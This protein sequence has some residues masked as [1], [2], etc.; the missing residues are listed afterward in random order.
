[1]SWFFRF[2]NGKPIVRKFVSRFDDFEWSEVPGD[3]DVLDAIYEIGY[4]E[5]GDSVMNDYQVGRWAPTA[6]STPR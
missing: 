5:G 3:P 2:E 4:E 6:P 1:M